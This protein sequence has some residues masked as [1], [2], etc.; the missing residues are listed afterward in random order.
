MTEGEIRVFLLVLGTFLLLSLCWAPVLANIA[1][2][3]PKKYRFRVVEKPDDNGDIKFFIE[4][5]KIFGLWFDVREWRFNYLH[6]WQ[7]PVSVDTLK[8]AV[9]YIDNM[10]KAE[11]EAADKKDRIRKFE[12]VIHEIER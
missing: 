6:A 9:E 1:T 5:R 8:E 7:E 3:R 2:N 10:I 11:W 4:E 12:P